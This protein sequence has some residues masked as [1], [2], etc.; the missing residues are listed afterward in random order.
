EYGLAIHVISP[1]SDASENTPTLAAKSMGSPT[2][3]LVVLPQDDRVIRDLLMYKRTEK[4][5]RQNITVTQRD[6]VK[7]ILSDKGFQNQDRFADLKQ[8]INH[9]IGKSKFY[10]AGSELELGGED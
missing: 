6:E 3:I 9:A 7:R 1:F 2:E 10:L 5:I 8:R 4:Y